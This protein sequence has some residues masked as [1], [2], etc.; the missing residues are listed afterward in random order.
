MLEYWQSARFHSGYCAWLWK[1]LCLARF[2]TGEGEGG[3]GG[4]ADMENVRYRCLWY[5]RCFELS[6]N[7]S[8]FSSRDASEFYMTPCT[9]CSKLVWNQ[10][11]AWSETHAGFLI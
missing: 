3:E 9:D 2:Q 11:T 10:D 7:C 5:C 8:A 4:M 1:P 6:R